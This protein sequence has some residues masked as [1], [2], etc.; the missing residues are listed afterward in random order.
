MLIWA[1]LAL[2]SVTRRIQTNSGPLGVLDAD[3]GYWRTPKKCETM[4]RH[5]SHY[6]PYRP[7]LG[8][9]T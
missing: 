1:F 4:T 3:T 6:A 5:I 2:Q 9:R 8:V 7:F